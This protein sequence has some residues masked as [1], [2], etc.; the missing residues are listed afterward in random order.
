V[1]DWHSHILPAMDDG[2]RDTAE[3]ISLLNMQVSQG[4]STVIA[5]PHFYANDE[6]VA[7]FLERRKQA[8]ELLKSELPEGAPEI[9]LGAEVKYYQGI[10]RMEDLKDLRIEG[11][12]LLLLEMPMSHWTEYMVRELIELSGKSSIKI[13]L[14]HVERYFHLQKQAVWDRLFENGI[15]AQVNASFFHSFAT[16]RKAIA[17]LQEGSIQ[18]IGS[19]CHGVTSRPPQI[20]KAFEVIRKKLGDEYLNQMNEYGYSLLATTSN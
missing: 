10:S 5:T 12:K 3:S 14:A 15:L 4:I 7:S 9:R 11:S 13:V 2:S 16:K 19:D 1:I 20:D 6:T 18:L 8:M 17:L